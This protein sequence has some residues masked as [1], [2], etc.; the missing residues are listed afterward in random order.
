MKK[1]IKKEKHN[2]GCLRY[3]KNP[4]NA[5]C[6][7]HYYFKGKINFSEKEKHGRPFVICIECGKKKEMPEVCWIS[8]I[9][10]AKYFWK[11]GWTILPTLC[12]KHTKKI[13]YR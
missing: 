13:K 4:V 5:G 7:C 12:P 9:E 2:R 10:A 11:L 3:R 1:E 8:D 6:V